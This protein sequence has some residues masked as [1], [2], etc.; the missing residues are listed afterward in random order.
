M[1]RLKLGVADI[2]FK[3]ENNTSSLQYD[4]PNSSDNNH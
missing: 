1:F 2:K 4:I 3:K